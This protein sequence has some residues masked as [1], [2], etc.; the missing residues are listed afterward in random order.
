MTNQSKWQ[1]NQRE[2]TRR[3]VGEEKEV[4]G[5]GDEAFCLIVSKDQC[6]K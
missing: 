5:G 1:M 3:Q 6:V 4:G 2:E